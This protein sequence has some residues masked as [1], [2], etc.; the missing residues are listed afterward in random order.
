MFSYLLEF[1]KIPCRINFFEKYI[2]EKMVILKT[3]L[4][5]VLKSF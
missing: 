4:E 5:S 1:D 2:F 3:L